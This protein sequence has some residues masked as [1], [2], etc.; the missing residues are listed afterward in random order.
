MEHAAKLALQAV[1]TSIWPCRRRAALSAGGG[2][3]A[4]WGAAFALP[5]RSL[6]P[7]H[8]PRHRQRAAPLFPTAPLWAL[9]FAALTSAPPASRRLTVTCRIF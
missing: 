2:W 4:P 3:M 6:Q 8:H 7:A 5:R 9:C 1:A